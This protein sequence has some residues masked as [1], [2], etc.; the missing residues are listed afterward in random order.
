MSALIKLARACLILV[1]ESRSVHCSAF[2]APT[3]TF[4]LKTRPNAD[5]VYNLG[6]LPPKAERMV[7][8]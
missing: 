8:T 1:N 5:A 4:A 2:E 3:E 7:K 6:F